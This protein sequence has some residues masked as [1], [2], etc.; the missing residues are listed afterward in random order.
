M[1][2]IPL[3][4]VTVRVTACLFAFRE[5]AS[6]AEMANVGCTCYQTSAQTGADIF[7]Q[8]CILSAETGVGLGIL[9]SPD[10]ASPPMG[11]LLALSDQPFSSAL[12]PSSLFVTLKEYMHEKPKQCC[13]FLTLEIII[14]IYIHL[15][16]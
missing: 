4:Q 9:R 6:R 3:L 13:I 14:G 5:E 15:C 8:S 1:A 11:D 10:S 7:I 2:S 16:I 12:T